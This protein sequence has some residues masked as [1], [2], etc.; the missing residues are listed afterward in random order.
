[1]TKTIVQLDSS[2]DIA[3]DDLF[4]QRDTSNSD[5]RKVRADD[6]KSYINTDQDTAINN[7]VIRVGSV[8]EIEG[9][10]GADGYQASLSGS[11]A[12]IFKFD[13][14]N[15]SSEVA[16]DPQQGIYIAPSSD[17][18]G[19]SGAW[20]RQFGQEVSYSPQVEAKWWEDSDDAVSIQAAIDYLE[21]VGGG[22]VTYDATVATWS[23]GIVIPSAIHLEMLSDPE[24]TVDDS[25]PV[26]ITFRDAS[27][28]VYRSKLS[29]KYRMIKTT[30]QWSTGVDTTSIG[31]LMENCRYCEVEPAARY[32]NTGLQMLGKG[33]GCVHNIVKIDHL[34]NCRLGLD[35]RDESVAAVIGYTNSNYIYGG[36]IG[37]SSGIVTQANSNGIAMRNLTIAF[38]D[39]QNNNNTIDG[40]SL[41]SLTQIG[42]DPYSVGSVLLRLDGGRNRITNCRY[43]IGNDVDPTYYVQFGADSFGNVVDGGRIPTDF[44]QRINDDSTTTSNYNRFVNFGRRG[45]RLSLTSD[46]SIGTVFEP[47][48]WDQAD[49]DVDG[50]WSAGLPNVIEIPEHV[51]LIRA[52]CNLQYSTTEPEARVLLRDVDTGNPV[53][54]GFNSRGNPYG[55]QASTSEIDVTPGQRFRLETTCASGVA[56][57]TGVGEPSTWIEIE[58]LN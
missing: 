6:L 53:M 10:T 46:Q 16:S 7:R 34:D 42:A 39:F 49:Y 41:E 56:N 32:F 1:M 33:D 27:G 14:S 58:V 37:Y 25:V 15:L 35:L 23:S 24:I 29:G 3:D 51:R 5:D 50:L 22:K 57:L 54:G 45:A 31:I 55:F 20:V 13:S 19:A 47:I 52:T 4:L 9:L 12:G 48:T 26:A 30:E 11:R 36:R 17:A 40:V 44:F 18:T 43:E 38:I 21:S 28:T 2:T 8:A